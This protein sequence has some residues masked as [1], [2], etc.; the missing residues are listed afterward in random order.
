MKKIC[1]SV[2]SFLLFHSVLSQLT[3]LEIN[4]IFETGACFGI[5]QELVYEGD[6]RISQLDWNDLFIPNIGFT[7]QVSARSFFFS[8]GLTSA[9][10]AVSGEMENF[11]FLIP[12]SQEASHYSWHKNNLDKDFTLEAAVGYEFR[13]GIWRIT[14]S[15]GFQFRNRKWTATDGFLQY[16]IA[17]HWTGNEP[18]VMQNGPVI[19]YEQAIWFPF[20]ALQI[21]IEHIV[22]H[23]GRWMYSVQARIYPRV[24]VESNDIHFL[25]D[26]QFYDSMQGGIGNSFTIR[27]EFFPQHANGLGFMVVLHWESISNVR[28]TTSSNKTGTA[29]GPAVITEGFSAGTEIVQ[30]SVSFNIFIPLFR[31]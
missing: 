19:S 30:S 15:G 3:A 9:I 14:P 25:R 11:D 26:M 6:S 18:E 21:G 24:S 13:F 28:G 1:V 20:A 4:F 17:G 31:R 5:T 7:T 8:F 27:N 2:L 12:G 22:P 23:E 29:T 10:P 16:P